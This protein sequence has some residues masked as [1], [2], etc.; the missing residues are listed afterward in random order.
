MVQA[1][2][3]FAYNTPLF[4]HAGILKKFEKSAQIQIPVLV[5]YHRIRHASMLY[6]RQLALHPRK[7][8]RSTGCIH[9]SLFNSTAFGYIAEN[10]SA[11]NASTKVSSLHYF[12]PLPY[13]HRG[14]SPRHRK[15]RQRK[16]RN[17][18][19]RGPSG[20][21]IPWIIASPPYGHSQVIRPR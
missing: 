6:L 3:N 20:A 5:A 21:L 11:L 19:L 12:R 15:D 18:E 10:S 4:C 1:P 8:S 14:L 13:Q 16:R 9:L 17:V 2:S 7:E